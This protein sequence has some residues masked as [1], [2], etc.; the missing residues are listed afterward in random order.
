VES[1]AEIGKD[2]FVEGLELEARVYEPLGELL[3]RFDALIC[4]TFTVP[5][6]PAE[7]D[8]G[9]PVEVDGRTLSNWDEILMTVPFNIASR[10]PV[11]SVPSGLARTGVPT[12]LSIVGKT[13]DDVTVFRVAAA[14]EERLPW[15]DA[16][17]RRP[18]L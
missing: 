18:A 3:E 10:C 2:A 6:L 1:S 8:E 15:L 17:G 12:G 16:P 11:M 9:D 5:A 4:P 13:Y 7:W 14:H